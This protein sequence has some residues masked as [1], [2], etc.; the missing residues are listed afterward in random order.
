MTVQPLQP[1]TG[2][3]LFWPLILIGIGLVWLLS[4]I[5]ILQSASIGVLFRLW[6]LILVIIGLDLLFG[7]RSPALGTLIGVGGVA[8]IVLL[9]LVGPS[10]GWAQGAE[11]KEASYSESVGDATS[12][13]VNLDVS[14]AETNIKALTDSNALF[15]ADVR[16]TGDVMYNVSGEAAKNISL[17]QENDD[18][19]FNF[20]NWNF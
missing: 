9:M 16:Y 12:A 6:P 2:R 19:T 3:S 7:R 1:R 8:L 15:Q 14:V 10:L 5:G 13:T 17:R 18:K 20:W 4:N 11:V